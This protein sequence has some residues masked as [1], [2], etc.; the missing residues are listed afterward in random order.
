MLWFYP[1]SYPSN[2]STGGQ[3]HWKVIDIF[4]NFLRVPIYHG[5][6]V[7]LD[8][9]QV[10]LLTTYLFMTNVLVRFLHFL[11][12]SSL[13]PIFWSINEQFYWCLQS[14]WAVHFLT[15]TPLL[16]PILHNSLIIPSSWR[17]FQLFIF[18]SFP[19]IAETFREFSFNFNHITA[20]I[21]I[22][23]QVGFFIVSWEHSSHSTSSVDRPT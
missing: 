12:V 9:I 1:R 14:T 22:P 5:D 17:S 16:F 21:F 3:L 15:A 19:Y 7:Y 11:F 20:C 2:L 13:V 10:L 18:I 6:S 8:N 23:V 4:F